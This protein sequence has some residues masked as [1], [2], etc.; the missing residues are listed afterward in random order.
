MSNYFDIRDLIKESPN[1]HIFNVIGQGGVGK[2]Y[3][4]KK[5]VLLQY[6]ENGA[7]FV[8]VRRWTTEIQGQMLASV[9][10]DVEQDEE[11]IDAW[12]GLKI[13]EKYETFH[14]LPRSGWFWL[15]GEKKNTELDFLYQ[16][17][18]V[19]CLSKATSFKGGTYNDFK[20]IIA[21]EIITDEGYVGGDDEPSKLDKIVNTVA[22]SINEII[23]I[24]CGN[25]D[26]NI[27]ASPYFTNMRLDYAHLQPNTAYYYDTRTKGGKILANNVVFIKLANY[28]KDGE[29]FLN[30]YTSNIWDTPE[31]E[32]RLT[33]EVKTNRFPQIEKVGVEHIKPYFKVVLETPILARNE[34]RRKLHIYY[35]YWQKEP[36]IAI[37]THA[38][39]RL[40]AR[41]NTNRIIYGR[42]DVLDIRERE[43]KQM[44]R[45]NIPP[46][47]EYAKL[48]EIIAGADAN[49]FY[50]TD[51]NSATTLYFEIVNQGN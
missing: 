39:N 42:Y 27:E 33:G 22:R 40:D 10:S 21:D 19:A 24:L 2:S 1:T 46:G 47:I 9:F 41:L 37:L 43:Y 5:Y 44:F 51:S 12:N 11:V 26:A 28:E 3:S 7:K 36:C 25:P 20:T 6:F 23:V 35:G 30:E 4:A 31:G 49:R 8:Y 38:E 45:M 15:V 50:F 16:I 32:M 18:R 14:V 29:S 17:G 13:A 34:F 48:R